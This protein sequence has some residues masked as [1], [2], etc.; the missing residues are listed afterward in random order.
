M[1]KPQERISAGARPNRKLFTDTTLAC[2]LQARAFTF[3][4]EARTMVVISQEYI[5]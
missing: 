5:A 4:D 1:E 2:M 3:C